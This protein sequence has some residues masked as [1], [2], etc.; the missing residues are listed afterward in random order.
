MA[1]S[2][3]KRRRERERER[4]MRKKR[5]ELRRGKFEEKGNSCNTSSGGT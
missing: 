1:L 3:A 5:R 4:K 2:C